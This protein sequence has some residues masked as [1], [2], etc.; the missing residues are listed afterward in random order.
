MSMTYKGTCIQ[1]ERTMI[2]RNDNLK[3]SISVIEL[4]TDVL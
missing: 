1:R 2:D 3:Q 4:V